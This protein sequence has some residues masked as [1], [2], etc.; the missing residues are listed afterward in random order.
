MLIGLACFFL[1]LVALLAVPVDVKF[2]GQWHDEEIRANVIIA[3][4]FGLVPLPVH[5]R[6]RKPSHRAPRAETR[7]GK[8]FHERGRY[9][10]TMLRSK[11]FGERLTRFALDTLKAIRLRAL[12]LRG[13]LGLDDPAET[14]RAWAFI[15]PLTGILAGVSGTDIKIDP[16]FERASL[17]F[18]G[19]G[20][21]RV[22]PIEM[23]V[24]L[25]AF[26]GS[27]TTLR[28]L[29]AAFVSRRK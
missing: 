18:D 9:I 10:V 1:L 23:L 14:G 11:G 2:S 3:W 21:I 20:E 25:I 7:K 15:G 4:M 5:P 27:P 29:R 26:I 19:D 22:F 16:D 6:I 28:A 13:R 8:R 24:L 12:R 17:D